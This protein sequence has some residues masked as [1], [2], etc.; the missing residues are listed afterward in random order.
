MRRVL[1]VLV[2]ATLTFPAFA[3]SESGPRNIDRPGL[4]GRAV[5]LNPVKDLT[6][7]DR[8][9]LAKEGLFV[10]RGLPNG[11]YLARLADTADL[12]DDA[13]IRSIQPLT[14]EQKLHP[15]AVRAAVSGRPSIEVQVLFQ[16]DVAFAQAREAILAAGG[17]MDIFASD[18]LPA[19]R[20]PARIPS[21]QLTAL[22]SDEAV[23]AIVGPRKYRIASDNAVSAQ[24]SKVDDVQAAP[25]G[26]TGQGVT[27]SLFE[28]SAMQASHVEFGGRAVIAPTTAGGQTLE[29]RH[30]TH[31]AGTI[32]AS[33]VKP[34]AKGMAPKVR[35]HEFCVTDPSI[36]NDC[37]GDWM[38]LKE[39]NLKPLGISIDNNSWGYVWGWWEDSSYEH[40]VVWSGTDIYWGAYDLLLASP[41]DQ[42]AT[43]KDILF[44][45]SAGN[46]ATNPASLM[47]DPW[48]THNHID[49]DY[50]EIRGEAHCVSQNGS[51]TDCPAHC[52][53]PTDRCEL[54][55]H[56]AITP[57]DTI[58]TTASGKNV[59]AVGGVTTE[60]Q[61]YNLSSRGPAKDGRVKPDVVA[62]GVLVHSTYPNDSYGTLTGTSMAAPVVTGTAALLTEQWKKTYSG[63]QPSAATL[64]ALLIAGTEDLGNPGPDY[65]FGFGLVDAKASVDLILAD[66]GRQE[67]IRTLSFAEGQQ[68]Q[69]ELTLVVTE[70]QKLRV[71]MNWPDPYIPYVPPVEFAD[72]ALVN[73]LDLKV[74]DPA[75]NTVLP[76]TLNK[77]NPTA[78][79]VR[80][81][82]NVDNIEM[83]EIANATPG[84]YRVIATGTSV[85]EGPQSAVIVTT[86]RTARP[87]SDVQEVIGGNS[88]G[89]AYGNIPPGHLVAAGLCSQGDVD[90]FKFNVTKTGPMSVTITTGDTAVRATLT[91]TGIS[92]TQDIPA[93]TTA[94]LH[95]DVNTVPNAV[96]LKIEA[97]GAL[98]VEPQY[99]FTAS[100]EEKRQPK[101]RAIRP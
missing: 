67:R 68:Q 80:G 98:G 97:T 39:D 77:D 13:R 2:L 38:D 18:F 22:A 7:Y 55:L 65:T 33:G 47:N 82:N 26:L 5:I 17:T 34:S 72:K 35:I 69:H 23:L 78:N 51:G 48:R 66:A 36:V 29:A 9:Q 79:A 73:N 87:C 86:A 21:Q 14:P 42:I 54:T 88:S 100:F 94:V 11:R 101:R 56:H 57:Y 53:A 71:V 41:I 8:A 25:Y 91:G 64:K 37:T 96:T 40:G 12:S 27:V 32:A 60:K 58:G 84:V 45:H 52:N 44:V 74:I 95:T 28:L 76:W 49:E 83:V 92:R 10:L 70:T 4:R 90:F 1:A 59:V 43:E 30:A 15:T 31:V 6:E 50:F 81:V 62:R 61:V 93:N 3:I 89:T 24:V 46:D 63:A 85:V 75:G 99:N 20:I 16:P 19:Q